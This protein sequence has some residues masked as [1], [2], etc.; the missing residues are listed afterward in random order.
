MRECK[1]VL[2]SPSCFLTPFSLLSLPSPSLTSILIPFS[3]APIQ[4]ISLSVVHHTSAAFSTRVAPSVQDVGQKKTHSSHSRPFFSL[5]PGAL[6]SV[7]S[8]STNTPL[9]LSSEDTSQLYF[10][11]YRSS[12]PLS[13]LPLSRLI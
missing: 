2:V 13:L 1:S 7:T 9:F 6:F 4:V 8:R 11:T 12:S 5:S 10:P 3:R